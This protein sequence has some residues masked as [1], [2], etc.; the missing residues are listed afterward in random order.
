MCLEAIFLEIR[1]HI[2]DIFCQ[3]IL[4]GKILIVVF[5]LFVQK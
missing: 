4:M 1:K 3:I 5:S 2:L